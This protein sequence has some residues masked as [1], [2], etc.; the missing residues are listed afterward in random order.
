MRP[1]V[2]RNSPGAGPACT[3]AYVCKALD[4][5]QH[6][7][8]SPHPPQAGEWPPLYIARLEGQGP[9][10]M[11]QASFGEPS[12]ATLIGGGPLFLGPN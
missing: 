1:G 12:L 4:E 5:A 9:G 8:L 11:A 6:C 10:H 2:M 3:L 7:L